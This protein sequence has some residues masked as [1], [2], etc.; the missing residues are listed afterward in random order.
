MNKDQIR[1]STEKKLE[2]LEATI[3]SLKESLKP[4]APDSAIG[5]LTRMEAI[6]AQSVANSSLQRAEI[7]VS[8]KGVRRRQLTCSR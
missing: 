3:K 7:K 4:V 1:A 6:Q 8:N 5:R 2:E